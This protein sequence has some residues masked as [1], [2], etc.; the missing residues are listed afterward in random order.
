MS[1]GYPTS[2]LWCDFETT[3]VQKGNDF[4]E[5]YPMEVSF[6]LTDLYFPFDKYFLYSE[7]VA[8][9]RAALASLRGNPSVVSMHNQSGLIEAWKAADP[10]NTVGKIEENV[11]ELLGKRGVKPGG[12]AL[13]GS[14]VATFDKGVIA[15][16][17]PKLNDMLTYFVFD[18]GIYRRLTMAFLKG[19]DNQAP[20]NPAS[21]G[22]IKA[23]R[24]EDDVLAHHREA[25]SYA[26]W[27]RKCVPPF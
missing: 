5:V 21:Y 3:T 1:V 13:A 27:L 14:G 26:E 6:L 9:N 25:V 11:L 12:V 2:L 8:P 18:I 20:N 24:A 19:L 22:S 23:H 16:H 17:M 7:V 15:E 10:V 4:S